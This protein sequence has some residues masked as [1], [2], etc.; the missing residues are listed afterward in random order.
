MLDAIEQRQP[1]ATQ[2]FKELEAAPTE[3][4]YLRAA[5]GRIRHCHTLS[6]GIKG[7]SY[8]TREGQLTALGR[9]CRNFPGLNG[10][11]KSGEFRE[12]PPYKRVTLSQDV[13]RCA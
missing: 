4:G 12:R 13:Q 3:K 8:R 9:E 5:S 6:S 11:V 1:R 10:E 7:L 2:F